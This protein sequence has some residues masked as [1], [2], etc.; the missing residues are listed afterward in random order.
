ML[1]TLYAATVD[2]TNA[3]N[4]TL[5]GSE[6]SFG[7]WLGRILNGAMVIAAILLLLYLLWGGISWISAGGDSSKIQ[8][9]RE[10]ITQAVIGIVVLAASIAIFMLIQRILSINIIDFNG[11]SSTG[12]ANTAEL[13]TVNSAGT[14]TKEEMEAANTAGETTSGFINS[15]KSFVR[16]AGKTT[17]ETTKAVQDTVEDN[18]PFGR[19]T[20]Y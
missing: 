2:F 7:A 16:Q 9:A 3:S 5:A 11:G 12:A 4:E 13:R 1:M 14:L 15:L 18:N 17:G 20:G 6:I 10:R 8:A 19:M